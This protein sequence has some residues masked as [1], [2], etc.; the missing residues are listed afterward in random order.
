MLQNACYEKFHY[1]KTSKFKKFLWLFLR[2][3]DLFYIASVA[4]SGEK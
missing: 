3:L 4:E 1:K 2:N